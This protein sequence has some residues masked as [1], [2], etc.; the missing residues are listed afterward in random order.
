LALFFAEKWRLLPALRG[1][2]ENTV[3]PCYIDLLLVVGV[4]AVPENR[5]V[6]GDY[7]RSRR[8]RKA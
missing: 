8:H 6:G 3:T 7:L 1:Q 4:R 5:R 2:K